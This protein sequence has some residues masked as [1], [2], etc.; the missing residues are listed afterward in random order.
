[1]IAYN[2]DNGISVAS[3]ARNV[4]RNNSIYS[5]DLLG[6]D[7]APGANA[8]QA[9]PVL[10]SVQVTAQN[11][12]ITG[13]L[14]S[15][16]RAKFTIEFFASNPGQSGGRVSLGTKTVTANAA[17]QVSFTFVGTLPPNGATAI[18]ATATNAQNNT[19][20]FSTVAP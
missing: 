12:R 19:S 10:T 9:A 11:I 18:T 20:E 3:G 2:D 5:N 8:N 1:M 4:I 6:I 7:L 14:A 13:T 16:P 17:G 15:K